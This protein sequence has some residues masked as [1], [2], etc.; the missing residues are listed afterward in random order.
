L[1]TQLAFGQVYE[2]QLPSIISTAV[3]TF[4]AALND[5]IALRVQRTKGSMRPHLRVYDTSGDAICDT[6]DNTRAI[7]EP[8]AIKQSGVYT[9]MV[10]D[11]S[12]SATGEFTL[13]T[14]RLNNPGNATALDFG[15][16]VAGAIDQPAALDAYTFVGETN[17]VVS[18]TMRRTAGTFQ[19]HLRIYSSG[20]E[21]VCN[22]WD[23]DEA[24]IGH[25]PL[26][27]AGRY[28]I[29][30]DD[31]NAQLVGNYTV[32]L[33]CVDGPCRARSETHILLPLIVKR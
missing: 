10:D 6:W 18:V 7:L 1:A 26:T 22:T 21:L 5:A 13:H 28:T 25:C 27:A 29:I 2:G 14:Q 23:N 24:L 20:G 4:S 8:C 17:D 15:P 30:A 33:E 31:L 16:E 11:L 32:S 19:P 3:Y 12:V 9:L